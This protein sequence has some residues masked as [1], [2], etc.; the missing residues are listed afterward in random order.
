MQPLR[1]NSFVLAWFLRRGVLPEGAPADRGGKDRAEARESA[2][3][4]AA[5]LLPDKSGGVFGES[6]ARV[7]VKDFVKVVGV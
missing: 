7:P 2:A 4:V 6:V 5:G 3:G 1:V